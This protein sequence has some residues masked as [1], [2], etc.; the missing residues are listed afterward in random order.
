MLSWK[1]TIIKFVDAVFLYEYRIFFF[2]F[3]RRQNYVWLVIDPGIKS[4]FLGC[5]MLNKLL[6]LVELYIVNFTY[7]VFLLHQTKILSFIRTHA[8]FFKHFIYVCVYV[9]MCVF[10]FKNFQE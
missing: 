4:L 6:N 2:F 3:E 5:P 8:L 7:E 1:L 10:V 9:Y